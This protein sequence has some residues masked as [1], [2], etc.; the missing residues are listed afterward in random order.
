M[1]NRLLRID[2]DARQ[3]WYGG[4]PITLRFTAFDVLAYL[5]SPPGVARTKAEIYR[6][7]W[8]TEWSP[9]A[10]KSVFE[11]IRAIRRALGDR[12]GEIIRTVHGVGYR[13]DCMHVDNP[14][15]QPAVRTEVELLHATVADLQ[16]HIEAR[17]QEI[18][19][20]LIAG[21]E[22]AAD[23]RAAAA[24]SELAAARQRWADLE[25]EFR[26]QIAALERQVP[27]RLP[28]TEG[29]RVG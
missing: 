28:L 18:A 12:H 6:N 14:P 27:R 23:E 4:Q 25:Q 17:A 5:A 21:A 26:R 10:S 29:A 11:I 9:G 15:V 16:G 20:P 22:R 2:T 7:A 19:A 13:L 24:E 1:G 8:K 3:A